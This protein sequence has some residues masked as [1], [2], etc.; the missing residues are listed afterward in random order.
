MKKPDGKKCTSPAEN[1]EVFR[2]HFEKLYKKKPTNPDSINEQL[3]QLPTRPEMDY[4]PTYKEINLAI[5]Q[6]NNLAAGTS[7]IRA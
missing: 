2:N 1:A 7:G 4:L 6:L 5:Q 3:N